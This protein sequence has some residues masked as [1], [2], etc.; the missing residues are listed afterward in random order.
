MAKLLAAIGLVFAVSCAADAPI[1]AILGFPRSVAREFAFWG[2]LMQ[3]T[4][5]AGA[6]PQYLRISASESLAREA[7]EQAH[8]NYRAYNPWYQVRVPGDYWDAVLAA[9]SAQLGKPRL[10][11]AGNMRQATW[12]L[13]WDGGGTDKQFAVTITAFI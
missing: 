2:V 13:Q 7:A 9:W 1:H 11:G 10:Y 4:A 8:T 3:A 5:Q 12:L 6:D